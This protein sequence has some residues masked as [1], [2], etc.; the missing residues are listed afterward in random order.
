M[1]GTNVCPSSHTALVRIQQYESLM[2]YL[3]GEP[4]IDSIA[5]LCRGDF[6]AFDSLV[7][8]K[9]ALRTASVGA[10]REIF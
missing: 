4:R 7:I 8:R 9:V 1:L 5:R 3:L 10:R 6:A 2:T